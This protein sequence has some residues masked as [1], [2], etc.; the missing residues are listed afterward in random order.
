MSSI[1][2]IYF[3]AKKRLENRAFLS[4]LSPASWSAVAIPQGGSDTALGGTPPHSNRVTLCESAVAATLC[5]R[6]PRRFA[7]LV[8][9]KENGAGI[10]PG[11]ACDFCDGH[12]PPLQF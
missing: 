9:P 3:E 5:R 6:T 10:A 8:P 11:P 7:T 12:R 2:Y 1:L 4:K